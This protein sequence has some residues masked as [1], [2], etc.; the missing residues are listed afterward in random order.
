MCENDENTKTPEVL[1]H[2][3]QQP[4][5]LQS[6]GDPGPAP[7]VPILAKDVAAAVIVAGTVIAVYFQNIETVPY[8]NRTRFVLLSGSVKRRLG[9]FF[10][11]WMKKRTYKRKVLLPDHEDNVRVTKISTEIVDAMKRGLRKEHGWGY[12]EDSAWENRT[13]ETEVLV[14]KWVQRSGKPGQVRGVESLIRNLEG[15]NWEVIVVSK[16]VINA[17]CLWGEKIVVYKGLLDKFESD[18]IATIG[19]EVGHVVARHSAEGISLGLFLGIVL[20]YFRVPEYMDYLW[21]L[22]YSRRW[23]AHHLI[24]VNSEIKHRLEHSKILV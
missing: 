21:E 8:T 17:F 12:P 20:D 19:H 9:E 18:E 4:G 3:L 6:L 1:L 24:S 5:P 15:L 16:P 13:A 23:E 11:W 2:L 10:F 7:A 22:P 14:D